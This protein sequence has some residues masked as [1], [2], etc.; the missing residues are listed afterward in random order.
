MQD[1]LLA[2]VEFQ[3]TLHGKQYTTLA[4]SRDWISNYAKMNRQVEINAPGTRHLIR[5][6]PSNPSD[7]RFDLSGGF[8]SFLSP[9]LFGAAGLITMFFALVFMRIST[10]SGKPAMVFTRCPSCGHVVSLTEP[11]CPKCGVDISRPS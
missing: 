1:S 9:A 11:T 8:G 5:Y 10:A 7:I 2:R 3:Y 4:G 6:N